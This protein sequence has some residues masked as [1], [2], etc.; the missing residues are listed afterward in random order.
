MATQSPGGE[1]HTKGATEFE[2][3]V[4]RTVQNMIGFNARSVD[5]TLSTFK[6]QYL[7]L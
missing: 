7:A 2:L 4:A 5:N 6:I 1:K 3:C